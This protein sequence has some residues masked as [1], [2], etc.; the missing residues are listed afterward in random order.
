MKKD[1]ESLVHV[2]TWQLGSFEF[3]HF[4]DRQIARAILEIHHGYPPRTLEDI[5]NAVEC[6]R[7]HRGNLDGVWANWRPRQLT[8]P[9]LAEALWPVLE[10]K[11]IRAR[12]RGTLNK[13]PVARIVIRAA[14]L[15]AQTPRF[16]VAMR[17]K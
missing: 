15:A 8:K 3:A 16:S 2:E 6:V 5:Q 13:I 4:T 17:L 1:I 11:L 12:E 10:R 7:E 14:K 9:R